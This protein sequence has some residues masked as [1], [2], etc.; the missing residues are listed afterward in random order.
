MK[1]YPTE[2]FEEDTGAGYYWRSDLKNAEL[3]LKRYSNLI[4]RSI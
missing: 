4:F 3:I 1:K 2:E